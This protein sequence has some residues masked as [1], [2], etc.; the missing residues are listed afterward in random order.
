M[1]CIARAGDIAQN[2][3]ALLVSSDIEFLFLY[4]IIWFEIDYNKDNRMM[5]ERE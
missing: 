1:K 3:P 2:F 5:Q 4:V